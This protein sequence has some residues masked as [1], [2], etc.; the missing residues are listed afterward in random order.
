MVRIFFTFSDPVTENLVVPH[1]ASDAGNDHG[2]ENAKTGAKAK[3]GVQNQLQAKFTEI[4]MLKK[5][6]KYFPV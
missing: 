4:T 3:T 6:V 5:Q 2:H 1:P